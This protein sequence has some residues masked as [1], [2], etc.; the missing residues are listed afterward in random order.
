M[1][2]TAQTKTKMLIVDDEEGMRTT[3]RRIMVARGFDVSIACDGEDGVR[4]AKEFDP[5]ILLLDIR[6][7]GIDGVETFRRLK[8][9][10]PNAFAVFMTAY[11]S[12]E[13]T[14]DARSEGGV[15]VLPK[16]LDIDKL[17]TLVDD[18]LKNAP[19]LIIDDDAGFR[20]SLERALSALGFHVTTADGVESASEKF[21][22]CPRG[23]VIV[24][25]K[26]K[27]GSGLE[28]LKEFHE[29]NEKAVLVATTGLDEMKEQ[30][31]SGLKSGAH[32]TLLKPIEI[33]ALVQAIRNQPV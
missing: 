8:E 1:N 22:R 11:A 32:C 10:C 5:D 9:I 16:P 28:V 29:R 12:S 6:M 26:L 2:A 20:D 7:P 30:L 4:I 14:D 33:D 23:V 31:E 13:L 19:V 25:M 27:D 3:L 17:N 24:D 21:E 15:A 18:N